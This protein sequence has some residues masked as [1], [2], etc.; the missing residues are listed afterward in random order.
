MNQVQTS[1]P[2]LPWKTWHLRKSLDGKYR[3]HT[4]CSKS[5]PVCLVA[6]TAREL[7]DKLLVVIGKKG[8]K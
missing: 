1:Y 7:A 4:T 5:K 2:I 8:K 3:F 6:N